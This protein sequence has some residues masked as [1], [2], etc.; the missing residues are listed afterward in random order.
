MA[1]TDDQHFIYRR[2]ELDSLGKVTHFLHFFPVTGNKC[3]GN[4]EPR[5]GSEMSVLY[6]DDLLFSPLDIDKILSTSNG[7]N[8]TSSTYNILIS[9][10]RRDHLTLCFQP[11]PE[12]PDCSF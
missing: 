9:D 6:V 7:E 4:L 2:K 5:L 10:P 3:A 12:I 11:S 8:S 1:V